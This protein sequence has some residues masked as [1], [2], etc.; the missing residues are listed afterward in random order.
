MR[1]AASQHTTARQASKHAV[2][3]PKVGFEV[4][5]LPDRGLFEAEGEFKVGAKLAGDMGV[6]SDPQGSRVAGPTVGRPAGLVDMT[7][8]HVARA[9]RAVHRHARVPITANAAHRKSLQRHLREQSAQESF[10]NRLPILDRDDRHQ[11]RP[12]GVSMRGAPAH[13]RQT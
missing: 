4:D 3:P 1:G 11:D 12:Q 7:G 9:E 10:V 13:C 2:A 5:G 6:D 8:D